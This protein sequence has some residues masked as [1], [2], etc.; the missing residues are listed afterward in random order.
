MNEREQITILKREVSELRKDLD[1]L[2]RAV[3]MLPEIG[4]KIQRNM[5]I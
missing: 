5:W 2:K 1:N 3:T 4:D